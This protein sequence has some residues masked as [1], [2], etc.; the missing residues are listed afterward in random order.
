MRMSAVVLA[1]I[2]IAQIAFLATVF[3]FLVARRLVEA[4]R[5]AR[6]AAERAR[7]GSRIQDVLA[8]RLPPDAFAGALPRGRASVVTA[9]LQQGAMQVRGDEWNALTAA[10]RRSPWYQRN[11]KGRARSRLWWRRLVGTRLMAI[12]GDEHDVPDAVRLVADRHP[13]VRL[14][15]V[16]LVRRLPYPELLESVLEQAIQAPRVTRQHYFDALVS[17]RVP[18]GPILLRRL[19]APGGAYELR[20]M[21]TLA[22]QM[23]DPE[24]LDRLLA[25]AA[26]ASA[27]AR[28]QVARALG[29]YPHP[30]ARDALV[31]LLRDKEWQVRTQAASS[32]GMIRALDAW[33]ALQQALSD[34]NWWVRLRAAIALRQLGEPGLDVLREARGGAD[35]FASEMAGYILG[36]SDEAVADHAA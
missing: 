12:V 20:A 30:R 6:R 8:H 9:G 23:A 34:E 24:L 5:L 22:G 7:L 14:A 10:V 19:D 31:I 29:G 36:L 2:A 28:T 33:E 35:R 21:L 25:H 16:Q 1:T 4:R 32:L 15:A 11:L 18:L 13:G 26:S 27:D 17:V 3:V